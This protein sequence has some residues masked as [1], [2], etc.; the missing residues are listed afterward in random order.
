MSS[1]AEAEPE[2]EPEPAEPAEPP[3][4]WYDFAGREVPAASGAFVSPESELISLARRAEEELRAAR[5]AAR[6][7][8]D[9]VR[10]VL[11]DLAVLVGRLDQLTA[12]AEQ[13]LVAQGRRPLYM[14]LRTLKNQMLQIVADNGI[15]LRDPTGLP[16]AEVLDW[17]EVSTW[18]HRAQYDA[19]VVARTEERAVFL[20]GEPVRLARVQMGAP[21][22]PEPGAAGHEARDEQGEQ[23]ERDE[24][25]EREGAKDA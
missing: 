23:A 13:P 20:D 21:A 8:A 14:Q 7:A 10:E 22:E 17:V 5:G 3:L 24:R 9:E 15:E 19:E 16:A 2:T 12:G 11:F 18:L 1:S 25:D 6:A 4:D